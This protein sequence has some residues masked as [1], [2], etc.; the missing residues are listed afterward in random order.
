MNR[1]RIATYNVHK[2]R[3]MDLKVSPFRVLKVMEDIAP[4]VFALQEIFEEQARFLAE[5]LGM[6]L[7]FGSARQLHSQPYGNAILSC[8]Q[9]LSFRAHDLSIRKREPRSCLRAD[10]QIAEDLMVHV[11]AVHLGTS[12]FERRRQATKLVSAEVLEA[13]DAKGLRV[14]TG[15]FN[16]WTRGLTT[17]MLSE[18]MQ[19]AD[20]PSHG[21]RSRSY[22]GV[23][24]V[25]HLDHMYYDSPLQ[26]LSLRLHRTAVAMAA[27]DHLP[28]VGEFEV[29]H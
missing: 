2:C 20:L 16:E 24:P 11:F 23:L 15:D 9:V 13:S 1:F 10:V 19:S 3:G 27:S 25:L 17:R 28:L 7:V 18:H 29:T 22:P 5:R 21:S 4:D 14:M 8:G 6:A 26:L 12:Y